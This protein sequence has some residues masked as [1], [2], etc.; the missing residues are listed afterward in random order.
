MSLTLGWTRKEVSKANKGA[1]LLMIACRVS[2]SP[3]SPVHELVDFCNWKIT[4]GWYTAYRRMKNGDKEM[5]SVREKANEIQQTASCFER[6]T[7]YCSFSIGIVALLV[8]LGGGA[9]VWL[10]HKLCMESSEGESIRL[11]MPYSRG[12]ATNIDSRDV[13]KYR[14]HE[15]KVGQ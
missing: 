10:S 5:C 9:R 4:N 14:N 7:T 2:S 8:V 11:I 1:F 13:D 6:S 3:H 15:L 12:A